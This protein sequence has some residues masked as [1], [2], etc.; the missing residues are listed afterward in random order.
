MMSKIYA[1][2]LARS[3]SDSSRGIAGRGVAMRATERDYSNINCHYCNK[4][5]HDYKNDCATLRQS[6]SRISDAGDGKTSSDVDISC[7]SRSRGSSSTRRE[8][9]KCGAHTVRPPPTTTPIA[10]PDRKAGSTVTRTLPKFVLRAFLGCAACEIS[11][12]EITPT[13]SPASRSRRERSS[14]PPSP[15][16]PA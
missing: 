3:N 16:E 5:G 11:L 12:C 15:L 2:D 7:I 4:F 1:D 6:I 13:R 10:A 8:G 9:G 14:L